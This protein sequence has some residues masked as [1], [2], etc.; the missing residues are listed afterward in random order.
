MAV[1]EAGRGDLYTGK[2]EI[3]AGDA[4]LLREEL[5]SKSGSV[6]VSPWIHF[7]YPETRR[8][9]SVPETPML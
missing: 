4:T 8:S 3:A 2:Y 1:L 9:R 6:C 7:I 5:M